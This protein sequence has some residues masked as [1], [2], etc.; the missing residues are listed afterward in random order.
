MSQMAV[1]AGAGTEVTAAKSE[2]GRLGLM[3]PVTGAKVLPCSVCSALLDSLNGNYPCG[4]PCPLTQKPSQFPHYCGNQ[5]F[6]G[7]ISGQGRV[8]QGR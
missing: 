5:M 2:R 3:C 1:L 8:G 4:S 7:N 6:S